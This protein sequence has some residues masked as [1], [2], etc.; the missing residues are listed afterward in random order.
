MNS[1]DLF[2]K[3]L[4]GLETD[5]LHKFIL[6][7]G[8]LNGDVTRRLATSQYSEYQNSPDASLRSM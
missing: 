1:Q 5:L 7:L 6:V 2:P 3:A 8:D 4:H